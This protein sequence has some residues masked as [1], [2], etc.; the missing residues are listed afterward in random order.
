[1]FSK[2]A[3]IL[4]S[5]SI[6]TILGVGVT[7][8]ASAHVNGERESDRAASSLSQRPMQHE[9]HDDRSG[10]RANESSKTH[11][12]RRAPHFGAAAGALGMTPEELKSALDSGLTLTDV[13]LS[14]NID[15]NKVI[16]AII[17]EGHSKPSLGRRPHHRSTTGRDS[18]A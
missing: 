17:N 18:G 15:I 13:A 11:R 6:F 10:H 16:D 8:V 12:D 5:S 2:K 1:M 7:S 3:K 4:V 14:K 9:D